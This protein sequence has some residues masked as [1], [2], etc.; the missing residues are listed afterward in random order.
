M[1][2]AIAVVFTL[3]AL[4]CAAGWFWSSRV[5]EVASVPVE[6]TYRR[7]VESGK[8]VEATWEA[9]PR[10]EVRIASP[11]GYELFGIFIPVASA[12]G[13]VVLSHGVTFSLYGSVK[14]IDLFRRRGWNVLLYDHRAHGRSGG[15]YKTYGV[16]DKYDLKAWV[17]WACR[18][19]GRVGVFGE[20]YGAATAL[21][22]AP[23]LPDLAFIISDCAFSDLNSLLKDRLWRKF[24]LPAMPL[25]GLASLI[26]RLRA[27]FYFGQAS[28]RKE[29]ETSRQPILF[30][31]GEF[32]DY[33]PTSMAQEMYAA[34]RG[35]K[36]LYIAPGAG[37]GTSFWSDPQAY[38]LQ[39][40]R[41][42]E[43]FGMD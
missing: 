1:Y 32:D 21:Q 4:G 11:F 19:G 10:Q 42:L 9:L 16:Y 27:G 39:V 30:I 5:I 12:K 29:I 18:H 36:M 37:H 34:Y 35:P 22:A 23:I 38:D 43:Q 7:E 20:S 6:Q 14:Y 13:T 2:I 40:G 28:P 15:R 17:D 33:I 41:F 3:A 8:L 24:H 25:L 31:H 26:S